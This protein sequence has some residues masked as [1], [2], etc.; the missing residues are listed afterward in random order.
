MAVKVLDVT[1]RILSFNRPGYLREAVLSVLSQEAKAYRIEIYDNASAPDVYKAVED[2][3]S[4][5]VVWHPTE[6][7]IG[8]IGNG[9]RALRNIQTKYL[10]L[11]HDDDRLLPGFLK[12]QIRF[13]ENKADCVAIACQARFINAAGQPVSGGWPEPGQGHYTFKSQKELALLY[14]S[15]FLGFPSIVYDANALTKISLRPAL[16]KV[17]DV[18]LL[19]DLASKGSISFQNQVLIEYRIHK[20]QDSQHFPIS[21]IISLYEF[22]LSF[23][24]RDE[25]EYATI[26]KLFH[27]RLLSNL[28]KNFKTRPSDLRDLYLVLSIVGIKNLT[29]IL[30]NKA[31]AIFFPGVSRSFYP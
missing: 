13:L 12:A 19:I 31:K 9:Q 20:D 4:K 5:E 8:A 28:L 29:S 3:L 25:P 2:L 10:Y 23:F 17:S 1:V 16:G 7:N 15:S 14:A 30:W 22:L 6:H 21:T 18:G 26:L 27:R 24:K 11:M